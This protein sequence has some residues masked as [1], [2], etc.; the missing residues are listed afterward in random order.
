LHPP[1]LSP[2]HYCHR[3]SVPSTH[4]LHFIPHGPPTLIAHTTNCSYPQPALLSRSGRQ[5]D[6]CSA[7]I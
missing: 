5:I 1:H 7:R 3:F 6:G 2:F 4:T